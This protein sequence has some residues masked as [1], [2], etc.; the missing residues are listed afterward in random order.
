[1]ITRGQDSKKR[2]LAPPLE[3]QRDI[4][5][6]CGGVALAKFA[7][8]CRHNLKVSDEAAE[9]SLTKLTTLFLGH[10]ALSDDWM[11][12]AHLL[13]VFT[14]TPGVLEMWTG[15]T[16]M[17]YH[18]VPRAGLLRSVDSER[19]DYR[20]PDHRAYA[21][22]T[23]LKYG[24]AALVEGVLGRMTEKERLENR[25]PDI[26]NLSE[27]VREHYDR[28]F[29]SYTTVDDLMTYL[30]SPWIR[31]RVFRPFPRYNPIPQSKACTISETWRDST[32]RS[33][34]QTYLHRRPRSGVDPEDDVHIWKDGTQLLLHFIQLEKQGKPLA[35]PG[36]SDQAVLKRFL[37]SA[38]R[39]LAYNR[40][41]RL[42]K[43][44]NP[45]IHVEDM[46]PD[47]I[48]DLGHSILEDNDED[49]DEMV[50]ED[51]EDD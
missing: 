2:R 43:L 27:D 23:A 51:A 8:T 15:H 50:D 11:S 18:A 32:D 24:D 36:I 19:T 22:K 20:R 39:H 33:V 29:T 31:S 7:C 44:M 1:M 6:Y 5:V 14:D 46:D 25:L 28:W 42:L 30:A 34:R 21:L 47:I 3:L 9:K 10:P 12:R 26:H 41:S 45:L 48:L 35:F 13:S 16:P 40:V 49:D 17:A 37:N 4:L 38:L